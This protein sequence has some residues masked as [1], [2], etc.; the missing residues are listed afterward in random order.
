[1]R[2]EKSPT[3]DTSVS[4]RQ[5]QSQDENVES[6]FNFINL[7]LICG[8]KRFGQDYRLR[9]FS[10]NHYMERLLTTA[11]LHDDEISQLIAE[12]LQG[13]NTLTSVKAR[14]HDKCLHDF[15][16]AP[17]TVRKTC[18]DSPETIKKLNCV[19]KYIEESTETKF[20]LSTLQNIIGKNAITN[21]RL[22]RKLKC[23]YGI[24]IRIHQS[25]GKET[26]IYYKHKS[27]DELA[28][29]WFE[30][31]ESLNEAEKKTFC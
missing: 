10:N 29:N 28:D 11:N 4:Q 13:I 8:K 3:P 27:A 20:K 5:E 31:T 15:L 19:Y 22:Y 17:K 2:K 21:T 1:M 30:D 23:R 18:G 26:I 7:C 24:D 14:Y 9:V 16:V 12:R 6:S 25:R